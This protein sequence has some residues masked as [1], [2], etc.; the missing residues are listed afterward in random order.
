MVNGLGT[1]LNGLLV[2]YGNVG[3][4]TTNPSGRLQISGSG[5]DQ[6]L[7]IKN[8][9]VRAPGIELLTP[10]YL[11]SMQLDGSSGTIYW[12]QGSTRT[13]NLTL[14]GN[15]GIGTSSPDSKLEILDKHTETSTGG[16]T[17][18]ATQS[19]MVLN[20]TAATSG[21]FGGGKMALISN[22]STNVTGF[23]VASLSQYWNESTATTS[24]AY[25]AV[26][27]V[28]NQKRGT[29]NY[30][31][32]Q[33]A[34]IENRNANGRIGNAYGL[35]VEINS[36]AGIIDEGHGVNI[37]DVHAT[38]GYGIYQRGANDLN[39]FAGNVGIGTQDPSQK[40]EVSGGV[41]VGNVTSAPTAGT[42]RWNGT[43]FEGYDGSAW[44]SFTA[45]GGGGDCT[46]YTKTF[47]DGSRIYSGLS[48]LYGYM[49]C[50][51]GW[52]V[53]WWYEVGFWDSG[54]SESLG[55]SGYFKC[56]PTYP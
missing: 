15:V 5:I 6:I 24:F 12:T 33:E 47:G 3:I 51:S 56:S 27:E 37:E 32:G 20:N 55:S 16:N 19:N 42:I 11:Y 41:K 38:L 54:F 14:S 40:L 34:S 46:C 28:I 10:A 7:S 17:V 13:L 4:G 31:Y 26:S 44:K 23:G 1:S 2:P 25:G 48:Y 8:T 29:I 43:D 36:P 45:T 39:Y 18:Y 22:G 53:D 35:T 21:K 9:D 30:A 52:V 49:N 50:G